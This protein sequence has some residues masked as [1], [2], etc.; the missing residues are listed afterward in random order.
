LPNEDTWLE[1]GVLHFDLKLVHS[2][3]I[4]CQWRVHAGNSINMLVTFDEF[5]RKLT[6]RMGAY[7]LFLDTHGPELSDI[8]RERLK[9]KVRCEVARRHG[10]IVGIWRSG[11]ST[12]ERLRAISLSGKIP[13]EIRRRLYGLLSGW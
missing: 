4:G 3:V 9:A 8:S 7:K 11:C 2:G 13:Y 1:T 12:V 6:P 10:S 5:N